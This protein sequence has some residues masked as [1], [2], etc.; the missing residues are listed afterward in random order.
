[1]KRFRLKALC[2]AVT[3]AL[4]LPTVGA[5]PARAADDPRFAPIVAGA[6]TNSPDSVLVRFKTGVKASTTEKLTDSLGL[7]FSEHLSVAN[8]DVYDVSGN[9]DTD[10]VVT[11][12][13]KH[14]NV[15]LAEPDYDVH[16]SAVTADALTDSMW[17][18]ENFG[19]S[20]AGQSGTNGVDVDAVPAWNTSTGAGV[21][22][23]VLDEGV[24]ISHPEL[25]SRIYRNTA[26]CFSDGIDHDH[27]GYVNDCNGWDFYHGDNTVF[28]V[29]DG[30]DHGTHVAGT[31]GA[32]A[33]NGVGG[34]GIAPNV[35]ILPLKFLGPNGGA[36][37]DAISAI[38]YAKSRG[39]RIINCSWGGTAYSQALRDAI[40]NSGMVFTVA[41]GNSGND[42]TQVPQYPAAF[43]LAN[44]LTVAAV[45]NRG[46]LASFSNRGGTT[47]VGAPGVNILST[48]PRKD[49]AGIA[50]D[51]LPSS[52]AFKSAFWGF[53][54][55]AVDGATTRRDL[56]RAQMI[57]LGASA[58]NTPIT[59]VD[60]DESSSGSTSTPDTR[61]YYYDALIASG[62]SDVQVIDVTRDQPGPAEGTIHGRTVIWETGY[63]VGSTTITTLHS[64][65]VQQLATFLGAGGKALVAGADAIWRNETSDL[66]RN[67]LG[68]NFVSEGDTRATASGVTSTFGGMNISL[69]GAD[70]PKHAF[71]QYQ[72]IVKPW[73]A[74]SLTTL[75][76]AAEPNYNEAYGYKNG[77]SMAAPHVAGVAALVIAAQPAIAAAAVVS[78]IKNTVKPLA[79]LTSVTT[80]GG[81]VNAAAAVAAVAPNPGN[82]ISGAAGTAGASAPSDGYRFVARD[83]GIFT[84]GNAG[85]YG[86]AGGE[87]L[88]SPIVA[89]ATTPDRSGYW[90]VGAD[91]GIFAYGNATSY[92]SLGGTRLNQPIVGIASTPSGK[93]YWLVA[94]DG[95]IFS[96]GD[97]SFYGST[98]AIKLNQPIVG[99]AS[100]PSGKGYWLIAR[101]GGIFAYGDAQFFGST[102]NI[103]LNQPIVAALPSPSGKGYQLVASDGG[104]FAFGD[105]TFHGS[106]GAIK[107]N[108]PIVGAAGTGNGGGYWLIA[109]D[110]GVFAFGNAG[111]FGS[112]GAIKLN[113]PIV[114]AAH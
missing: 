66:V 20:I 81:M 80:T 88:N 107:L 45:D 93:G 48:M 100:T 6:T 92:G 76:L 60:D 67:Y 57:R 78:T 86:S 99:I 65:D 56:L 23:G 58:L 64:V 55:E 89:I 104:L 95:G 14:S 34:A 32:V 94:S 42:I 16:P 96:Y 1:M 75:A 22:V 33:N 72:D 84:F 106:T 74:E 24:D 37:S 38:A 39:A 18:L 71:H 21:I 87:R 7:D 4:V 2:A 25:A 27:N 79:S 82:P 9:K 109:S 8:V 30:D 63:A 105:A 43:N 3:I 12:L 29:A 98:G 85:F 5:S 68:V 114:G 17:G 53:G 61:S 113:Q 77:T 97:A 28:D 83:G 108:Q 90:L 26:D 50:I 112:T 111:F 70:S 19:Q 35:T 51:Y 13:R 11:A 52:N 62:Y 46:N 110:G 41:A 10:D 49:A 40:A 91:G 69:T 73:L 36:T 103:K 15:E 102:G 44:Q 47:A 54:L 101:D 31:I 59:I